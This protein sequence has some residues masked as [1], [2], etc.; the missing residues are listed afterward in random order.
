MVKPVYWV[1][2]QLL[3]GGC[4]K[5]LRKPSHPYSS[6]SSKITAMDSGQTKM[7]TSAHSNQSSTLM[8]G[9][10]TSLI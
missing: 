9:I 6:L 5:V 8:K 4:N 1:F 10:N 2:Q 7:P 3:T